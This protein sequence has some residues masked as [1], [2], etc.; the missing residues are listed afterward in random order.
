MVERNVCN[1]IV[2]VLP[3]R[4]TDQEPIEPKLM[5]SRERVFTPRAEARLDVLDSDHADLTC[6]LGLSAEFASF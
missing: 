6:R 1:S 5:N 4:Q 2:N 3:K